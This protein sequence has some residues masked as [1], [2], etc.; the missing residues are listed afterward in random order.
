MQFFYLLFVM[1]PLAPNGI[2]PFR[3][4]KTTAREKA[5]AFHAFFICCLPTTPSSPNGIHPLR[6]RKMAAGKRAGGFHAFFIG[7]LR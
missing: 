3:R 1:V 4:R 6:R 7:P 5:G 2:H